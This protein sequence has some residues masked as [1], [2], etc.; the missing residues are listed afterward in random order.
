MKQNVGGIDQILRIIAGIAL[1]V[2]GFVLSAE[3]V[4]WAAIGA[5]PLVTGLAG[6]C[7]VYLPFGLSTKK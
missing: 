3:P 7:P 6:W 2:W 1:L 4:L 5:V